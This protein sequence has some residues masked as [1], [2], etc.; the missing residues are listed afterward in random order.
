[1]ADDV[2]WWGT[3]WAERI[4]ELV[5]SGDELRRLRANMKLFARRSYRWS[6]VAREW[7]AL[8]TDELVG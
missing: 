4:A 3:Q 5:E 2:E 6:R 7:H 1:L 8:I